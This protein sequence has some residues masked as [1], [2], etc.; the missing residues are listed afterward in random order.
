[1]KRERRLNRAEIEANSCDSIAR[2]PFFSCLLATCEMIVRDAN[3]LHGG[4]EIVFATHFER[5]VTF[6]WRPAMAVRFALR[7][8]TVP[9][10]FRQSNVAMTMAMNVQEHG[11]SH[12]KGIF[13]DPR[14]GFLSDARQ[15]EN[16]P[17]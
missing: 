9:I 2:R 4:I 12:E 10:F 5:D 1:M 14:I 13:V 16:L 17:P 15:T 8:N 3:Q 7:E 11:S 6:F